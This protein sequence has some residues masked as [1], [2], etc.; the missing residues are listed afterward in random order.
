M[1]RPRKF[2]PPPLTDEELSL[3]FGGLM[4]EAQEAMLVDP[5]YFIALLED[6]A[7]LAD[8]PLVT[9]ADHEGRLIR[10]QRIAALHAAGASM[11][12]LSQLTGMAEHSL[13][14]VLRQGPAVAEP[15]TEICAPLQNTSVA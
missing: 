15:I 11:R 14:Y 2:R 6:A 9:R 3:K 5:E 13:D 12:E 4:R 10:N 8:W 1:A 7:R